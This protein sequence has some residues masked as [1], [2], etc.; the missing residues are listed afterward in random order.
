MLGFYGNFCVI[1]VF[2]GGFLIDIMG[3]FLSFSYLVS[4]L[5]DI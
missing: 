4:F 5:V 3:D 1:Y 2:C